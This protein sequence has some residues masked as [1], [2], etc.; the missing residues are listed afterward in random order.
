M[1]QQEYNLK[2][3]RSCGI[4]EINKVRTMAM[5]K[6]NGG[7]EPE[8]DILSLLEKGRGKE[9]EGN[10]TEARSLYQQA[11]DL[12]EEVGDGRMAAAAMG[13]LSLLTE[14]EGKT[15]E[16]VA[17]NEQA[18]NLF[19]AAGDAPG[20]LMTKRAQG[21]MLL[22]SEGI[23]AAI[24][25]LAFALSLSLQMEPRYV[26]ETLR[27]IVG[28]SRYLEDEGRLEDLLVLGAGM[29]EA[30][31]KVETEVRPFAE[32]KDMVWFGE[33]A[34]TLSGMF[35]TIGF[36]AAVVEGHEEP[37]DPPT[38]FR[39]AREAVHQAW[40][41]DAWTRLSW[42]TVKWSEEVLD[43]MVDA[44]GIREEWDQ[45]RMSNFSLDIHDHHDE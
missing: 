13:Q 26:V 18:A 35:S 20:L 28:V 9:Q 30:I 33:L 36:L 21:L 43:K 3:T 4:I 44:L 37:I 23:E 41:A 29:N 45:A 5:A 16:A 27:E 10:N 19:L 39:L 42:T 34:R 17:L 11:Y 8:D 38:A 1:C 32:D 14:A 31:R 7:G 6:H 15:G 25:P 12:A 40:L 2:A 24:S 22:R